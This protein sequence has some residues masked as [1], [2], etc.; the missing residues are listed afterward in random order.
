MAVES[1]QFRAQIL[2]AGTADPD[3]TAVAV[4]ICLLAGDR[5][6]SCRIDEGVTQSN[7]RR[8]DP[9]GSSPAQP[10]VA[11][12]MSRYWRSM[13]LLLQSP[14]IVMAC[15]GQYDPPRGDG[16]NPGVRI[17]QGRIVARSPQ[18][19]QVVVMRVSWQTGLAGVFTNRLLSQ[20]PMSISMRT[21]GPI[22]TS[23]LAGS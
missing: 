11:T 13:G 15:P 3:S 21:D 4:D 7:R 12:V 1:G 18:R 22:S 2:A 9:T 17:Q 16:L 20:P 10:F 8:P 23:R 6:V 14:H 5:A 19:L